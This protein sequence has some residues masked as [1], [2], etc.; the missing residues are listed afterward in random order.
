VTGERVHGD[1]EVVFVEVFVVGEAAGGGEKR[2]L[3]SVFEGEF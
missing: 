3:C 1:V 2:A